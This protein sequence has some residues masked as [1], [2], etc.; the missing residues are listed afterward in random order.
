MTYYYH[1]D[2]NDDD[3]DENKMKIFS[4]MNVGKKNIENLSCLHRNRQNWIHVNHVRLYY[5]I[6]F[7]SWIH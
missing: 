3:D 5:S 1:Y 7:I 4:L 2:N 6:K